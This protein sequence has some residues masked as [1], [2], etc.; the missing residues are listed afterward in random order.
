MNIIFRICNYKK[1][2]YRVSWMCIGHLPRARTWK[3]AIVLGQYLN[4]QAGSKTRCVF[5]AM[6][7][8]P[9]VN[10]AR[11]PKMNLLLLLMC[12]KLL[13]QHIICSGNVLSSNGQWNQLK[14][15]CLQTV[16]SPVRYGWEL[17]RGWGGERYCN[18]VHLRNPC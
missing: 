8:L 12:Q 5:P 14:Q 1:R 18:A 11:A 16:S 6:F 2:V 9:V 7:I 10:L 3:S 13:G 17:E 15:K 4:L